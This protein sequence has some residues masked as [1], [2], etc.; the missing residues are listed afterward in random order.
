MKMQRT[1]F[2][3]SLSV[4]VAKDSIIWMAKKTPS[5][6]M[7]AQFSAAGSVLSCDWP[8]LENSFKLILASQI[9][10]SSLRHVFC[11]SFAPLFGFLLLHFY[12]FIYFLSSPLDLTKTVHWSKIDKEIFWRTKPS[13][14]PTRVAPKT[15]WTKERYFELVC[16]FL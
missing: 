14:Q 13:K 3:K 11:A 10:A 7:T 12:L 8:S 5:L 15:A 1:A 9:T 2:W 4:K 6:C 16:L